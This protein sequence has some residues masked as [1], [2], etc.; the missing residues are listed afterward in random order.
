VLISF[1]KYDGRFMVVEVIITCNFSEGGNQP[2]IIIYQFEF[3]D[4]R[5]IVHVGKINR[6]T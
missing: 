4:K 2:T 6:F 1:S 3:N 5:N